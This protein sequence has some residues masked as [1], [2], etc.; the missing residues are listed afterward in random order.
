MNRFIVTFWILLTITCLCISGYLC[1]KGIGGWGWFLFVGV[2]FGA[3][4]SYT[5]NKESE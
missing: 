1:Y 4:I 5:E 2:L 3:G